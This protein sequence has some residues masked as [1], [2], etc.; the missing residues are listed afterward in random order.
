MD[1]GFFK[2][3]WRFNAV[4]IA[5]A[6][7]L[8]LAATTVI[9]VD[10]FGWGHDGDLSDPGVS[11][12]TDAPD[13]SI[14]D[15]ELRNIDMPQGTNILR[16]ELTTPD[17]YGS[18]YSKYPDS[19]TLNVGIVDPVTLATRWLFPADNTL[20]LQTTDV[21]RTTTDAGGTL[22]PTAV[23]SLY[24]VVSA[25]TNGDGR[26]SALDRGDLMVSAVDGNGLRSLISDVESI[27]QTLALPDGTELVAH[28]VGGERRF[29]RLEIPTLALVDKPVPV[30][31][32][33]ATD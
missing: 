2:W 33:S 30:V 19:R 6:T 14:P 3:L 32:P 10:W 27:D 21:L 9:F 20:I 1:T 18:I 13:A 25:D 24:L 4:A 8:V 29:V 16:V 22:V 23:A 11:V 7:L 5:V 28:T 31:W 12:V 26:L 15:L 17:V